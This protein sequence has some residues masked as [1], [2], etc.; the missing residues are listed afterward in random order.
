M[1]QVGLCVVRNACR[2][3]KCPWFNIFFLFFAQ[4]F[5]F[6]GPAS[7]A[8]DNLERSWPV[9]LVGKGHDVGRGKGLHISSLETK[10]VGMDIPVGLGKLKIPPNPGAFIGQS[11]GGISMA[12]GVPICRNSIVKKTESGKEPR[13]S[14]VFLA[15]I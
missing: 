12:F 3:S 4:L 1:Q 15:C 6:L 9:L 11:K 10:P 2:L 7:P 8:S 13:Y 5:F 14:L